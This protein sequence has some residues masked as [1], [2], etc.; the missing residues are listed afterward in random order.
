MKKVKNIFFYLVIVCTVVSC[1]ERVDFQLEDAGVP[2]LV[3]FAEITNDIKVHEVRLGK[4]APYFYNK[5]MESVS[6]AVVTIDDGVRTIMLKEDPI[7]PGFYLT[8]R[9]YYGVV[10]RKYRLDISNVDVNDDG[11]SE[12][13]SAET[14]MKP[15]AAILGTLVLRNS[16]WKGWDVLI[17]SQDRKETTDFY[18]FKIYKNRVLITD[19][20]SEYWTTD[21]RFFNGN[22]INGPVVQHFDED[23]GE[24][25]ER[26]D[27][28]TLEMDGITE[29]YFDYINGV[30]TEISEKVPL[31]SGPSA[32]VTG[33]ISNGAFG[34]F[35]VMEVQRNSCVYDGS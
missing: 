19:T 4:S 29:A 30:Q 14:E 24:I 27:T 16:S 23:K 8:P 25:V 32:N 1:T 35:A 17:Y 22:E 26:G 5:T 15:S 28:I 10:G 13:Y 6:N 12:D 33:N 20:I 3:V 7:R 2:H 18:L 11:V 31:F 34:F 21:D 9:E